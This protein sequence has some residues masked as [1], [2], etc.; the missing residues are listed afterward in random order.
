MI[1]YQNVGFQ[2]FYSYMA[3]RKGIGSNNHLSAF[4]IGTFDIPPQQQHICVDPIT[5]TRTTKHSQYNHNKNHVSS[6]EII[7]A[8]QIVV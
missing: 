4:N 5:H 8:D 7:G 3:L 6:I 2:R 1:S